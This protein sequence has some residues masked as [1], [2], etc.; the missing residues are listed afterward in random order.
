V[1]EG[2]LMKVVVINGSHKGKDGNT[3]IM[4]SAFLKGAY[5]AGAETVNI[6]LA[7]KEIKYCKACKACWFNS[8]GQCVIK[9]DI[10]EILSL[11]EG[12]DIRVLATPLYFDNI[13][14]MLKVFMDR[15]IVTAS[16][17]WGKDKDGECRHLTTS[18]PPK[19]MMIANC[20]YPEKSHFQVISHWIKRHAR[21]INTEIIGEIYCAQG[22]LLST[23]VDEVRPIISNYLKV[24]ETAG[25]EIATE[26]K[27]TEE[28][29]N[30]LEQNFIPDEIYI[31][32][33]KRYV[34]VMLKK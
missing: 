31:Q 22:A 11:M 17:Y 23:K 25:K 15:M 18:F 9:D 16:P 34:D 6:F 29:V 7:E 19:L 21:N 2:G 30:L 8:P 13:S 20:G 1:G 28:T 33:V 24:L 12:A 26:M 3:N 27:L 5:E 10:A 4:V 14:S 32:E